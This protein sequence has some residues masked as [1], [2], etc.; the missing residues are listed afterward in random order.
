M[1]KKPLYAN[2]PVVPRKQI[3]GTNPMSNVSIGAEQSRLT[4]KKP[5]GIHGLKLSEQAFKTPSIRGAARYGQ[6]GKLGAPH[7]LGYGKK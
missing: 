5:M 4:P 7:R 3:A 6:V 2:V 1:A